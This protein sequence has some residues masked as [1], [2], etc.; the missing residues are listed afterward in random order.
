MVESK[1]SP[2]DRASAPH[3]DAMCDMDYVLESVLDAALLNAGDHLKYRK[4][5]Q[6]Q[7][8]RCSSR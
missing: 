1:G 2:E 3:L 8:E 5:A 7:V 4:S 6:P